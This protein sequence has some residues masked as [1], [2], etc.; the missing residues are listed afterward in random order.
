MAA[1]RCRFARLAP[2]AIVGYLV[3]LFS[4]ALR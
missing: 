1:L 4:A 3:E 2:T